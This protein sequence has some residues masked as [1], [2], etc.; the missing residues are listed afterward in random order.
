MSN[1]SH[2]DAQASEDSHELS[3]EALL[4]ALSEPAL[5]LNGEGRIL[6]G[7]KA[8]ERFLGR[9]DGLTL[10]ELLLDSQLPALPS[11]GEAACL[12]AV[13][14]HSYE[15]EP[16]QGF[17]DLAPLPAGA[18]R[19]LLCR[20]RPLPTDHSEWDSFRAVFESAR[21][22]IFIKDARGSF[23]AVNPAMAQVFKRSSEEFVGLTNRDLFDDAAVDQ[24][25]AEDAEVLAGGRLEYTRERMLDGLHRSF[26]VVK[27]PLRD[28]N[29][30]IYGI[31]GIA[32]EVTRQKELEVMLS[33]SSDRLMALVE[34]LPGAIFTYLR[35]PDGGMTRLYASPGYGK[36]LGADLAQR[37]LSGELHH[38]DLIHP[39][40]RAIAVRM[41]RDEETGHHLFD[42][43]YRIRNEA[44]QYHWV[45]INSRGIPQ[46]N[47]DVLWHGFLLDIHDRKQ[48]GEQ[49][50]I[51]SEAL[52]R[53]IDSL[54][55]AKLQAEAAV[56]TRGQFLANMSHEI[57]TP[58]TA[59]LG[60]AEILG[61]RL[62]EEENRDALSVIDKNGKHLLR[63]INDILDLSKIEAGCFALAEEN[64]DP[65]T[66]LRDVAKLVQPRVAMK[67][68]YLKLELS[69]SLP[70]L[71]KGDPTRLRQI[72]IN[73]IGNAIKFTERGGVTVRAITCEGEPQALFIDVLDTGIGIDPEERD[74]L[75]EAFQ[76]AD[77]T[78]SRSYG[79]TGLGLTISKHLAELMGGT[80]TVGDRAGGGSCF[81]LMLPVDRKEEPAMVDE[82]PAVA[83]PKRLD[84]RVLI[85]E[86]NLTNQFIIQTLLDKAGCT[87]E[88]VQTGREAVE[89]ALAGR[90]AG[91]AHDAVL[92]DIQMPEMDG[93][94]ATRALRAEGF[95]LPII[96][97][98]A[99]T[100]AEDRQRCLDAGC[101]DHCPKPI[102][103]GQLIGMLARHLD[104][105][106][107]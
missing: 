14:F 27:T 19:F 5:L 9:I 43:E 106:T 38:F 60:F 94:A 13:T 57:R 68:L 31:C 16:R 34:Y 93:Y 89:R 28:G 56:H 72:L 61:D 91:E 67:D 49:L 62:M 65:A 41:E 33:E 10:G 29:G 66:E 64:I 8:A 95:T 104:G 88:L 55:Q 44:G 45:H 6:T 79:G 63:I 2:R 87:V 35:H 53:S 40:D 78:S 105:G 39:D 71:I 90:E 101:D 18:G 42:V 21:D 83:A 107:R 54:N 3:A 24:I 1:R 73:L 32:R 48:I 7:N 20:L 99:H 69:D 30:K 50:R 70:H 100:L 74:R 96:A 52:E 80:L 11:A 4:L 77:S 76:Q 58:L 46:A 82:A 36:I 47:G 85:A 92:M 15:G 17:L 75:F 12:E 22:S 86:D 81:R 26:H 103:S 25:D 98:T 51:H 102:D 37:L 84:A 97:L 23:L 59:V